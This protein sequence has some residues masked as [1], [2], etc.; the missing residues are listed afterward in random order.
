MQERVSLCWAALH[1]LNISS[2]FAGVDNL[3]K[4]PGAKCLTRKTEPKRHNCTLQQEMGFRI[5][6]LKG[7]NAFLLLAQHPSDESP[8]KTCPNLSVTLIP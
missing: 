4:H 1:S 3:S 8:T 6:L 5:L 7:S 2:T